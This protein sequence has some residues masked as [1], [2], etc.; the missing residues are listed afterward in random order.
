MTSSLDG[1]TIEQKGATHCQTV[2]QCRSR[3]GQILDPGGGLFQLNRAGNNGSTTRINTGIDIKNTGQLSGRLGY[4][5]GLLNL[6][7]GGIGGDRKLYSGTGILRLKH[8]QTHTAGV[9]H[10]TIGID[11]EGAVTGVVVILDRYVGVITTLGDLEEA[12]TGD[13][14]IPGITG[15][16]NTALLKALSQIRDLNTTTDSTRHH[17]C[18]LS[19]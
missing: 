17:I 2:I 16:L 8:V 3:H 19:S 1:S 18:K 4:R 12:S 15:A 13:R 6:D 7:L 5:I 11:T 9:D 10:I 14:Q